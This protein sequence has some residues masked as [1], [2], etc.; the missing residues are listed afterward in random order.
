MCVKGRDTLRME[1]RSK[2]DVRSEGGGKRNR[3]VTNLK[4]HTVN[5]EHVVEEGDKFDAE[6]E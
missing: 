2:L 6:E 1:E 4:R 3:I 5:G